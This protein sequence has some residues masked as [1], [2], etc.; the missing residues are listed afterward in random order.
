MKKVSSAPPA[1]DPAATAAAQAQ[2]NKD[3]AIASARLSQIDEVTPWGSALYTPTGETADGIER[4][5]RTVTLDPSD[6]RSLDME[7][8]IGE[9]LLGLGQ[10]QLGRIA[11]SVAQ[12]F[13]FDGLP[14]APGV[15][16]AARKA[17]EDALYGRYTSRLDPQFD[18]QRRALETRLANQGIVQG[19]EAWQRAMDQFG[20]T[21]NDAYAGARRDA[22]AGGTAE[23]SNLF[24]LRSTAR[25]NAL[26]ER[27]FERGLPLQELAAFM[28][29]APGITAPTFSSIPT[30]NVAPA[31]ITG[32][33]AMAYQG[34]IANAQAKNQASQAM[35]GNLFGL[36]KSALGGW[37]YN[38]FDI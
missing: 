1:P 38:N 9:R 8:A 28:G 29:T 19:T 27:T 22:V 4:Y 2:L 26:A 31:D 37:A 17:A 6:Q 30:Q 11:N 7:R 3:A 20:R 5:Q 23:L 16:D 34:Q 36:G 25:Q 10:D 15:D 14:E 33:T 24:G 35:W 13:S 32:P 21:M 12:P 18:E